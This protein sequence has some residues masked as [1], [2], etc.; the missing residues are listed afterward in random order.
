MKTTLKQFTSA[1]LDSHKR[2]RV[3]KMLITAFID[4][5][6][7]S[8]AFLTFFVLLMIFVVRLTA[9]FIGQLPILGKILNKIIPDKATSLSSRFCTSVINKI[10]SIRSF[11]VKRYYLIEL[12][13]KNL[14]IKKGRSI[15]TIL[16]M[17]VGVGIIVYLLSLGYGIERLVISKVAGL[18]ELRMADVMPG[19]TGD[20]KLNRKLM[21]KI[22]RINNVE[23]VLPMVSVVGKV[24]YKNAKTDILSYAVTEDYMQVLAS[25][26]L[27][28]SYFSDKG[29][30][31]SMNVGDVKGASS[32]NYIK[33]SYL[34][35]VSPGTVL[36]N[37]RGADIAIA[38]E[39]CDIDS[40]ILGYTKRLEGGFIG[41][42]Y[43]GG[44]YAPYYPYGQI[45]YDSVN[46]LYLGKWLKA[47][48]PLFDKMPKNQMQPKL[49][50]NGRQLWQEV[51][52]PLKSVVI[53]DELRFA[54]VLGE[55]TQSG[56]V[57]ESAPVV[58]TNEE[59]PQATESAIPEYDVTVMASGSG[60]MELVSLSSSTSA[61]T[62][63][64]K[65]ELAKFQS[66]PAAKAVI[67]L[68]MANYLG[69]PVNKAINNSFKVS[70][71]L[72]KNLL[73][74]QNGKLITE[75]VKYD[76][77]GIIQDDTAEYFYIPLSDMTKL[78]LTSYSQLKVI[79]KDKTDLKQV[80]HDIEV[81][82]VSTGSTA[83]TVAQIEGLFTN[84][85]LLLGLLGT[86]ALGV[87]A[88]GMFNTLT[89]SLLER[90]REIGGMKTMGMVSEEI[91]ELFLS[92]AMIMGFAGGVGGL[93][94]GYLIG[95]LTSLALSVFAIASGVGYLKVSYIP[96]FLVLFILSCSFFVGL[97]TG[98][99]PAQRAKKT[100]ALNALR[101]E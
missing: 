68:G 15:I 13:F 42:Q 20:V 28:G 56:E 6:K 85:R 97:V 52:L 24:D 80:R 34:Q 19:E 76:I 16:G 14:Q 31:L 46:D 33:A 5:P 57:A 7:N 99:Y 83:D 55:A 81:L 93:L 22:S 2:Q 9:N 1:I 38:R 53:Q 94:L 36:F 21:A 50:D 61:S 25:Q 101:Y 41:S 90:T 100:S 98:L 12:A 65:Q 45:A 91:Q 69:I 75:E 35:L 49:D 66:Q 39:E 18:N 32:T 70:F 64:E 47:K 71:I 11:K 30:K 73:G 48:V 54:Q 43:Y 79:A 95:E 87:A 10:E 3:I 72:V 88:L 86:I 60:G 29:K 59:P 84:I 82:G 44:E 40:K 23:Q 62:V 77:I 92:E 78:G 67:S 63:T 58:A 26:F 51:C 27:K 74:N 4:L 96:L 37:I 17:S 89:V 8:L